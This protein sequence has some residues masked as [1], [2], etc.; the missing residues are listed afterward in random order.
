LRVLEGTQDFSN[1]TKNPDHLDA[2]PR[3][4]ASAASLSCKGPAVRYE[5]RPELGDQRARLD[6]LRHMF[7]E[8]GVDRLVAVLASR[9]P[10]HGDR[11][12]RGPAFRIAL[13]DRADQRVAIAARHADVA[14]EH[15]HRTH[16][17][18]RESLARRS[19]DADLRPGLTQ[20]DREALPRVAVVLAERHG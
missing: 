13:A 12:R 9:Q 6:G 7:V 8:S 10:G 11:D 2:P 16:G 4:A 20:G 15:A 19:R 17:V 18:D 3:T 1:T 5:Q 14:D